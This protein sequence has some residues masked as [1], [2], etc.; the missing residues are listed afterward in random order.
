MFTTRGL[1][2]VSVALSLALL[3]CGSSPS[4]GSS[5]GSGSSSATAGKAAPE[6]TVSGWKNSSPLTLSGLNGKVVVLEF[7]A[8]WCGPC[9]STIAH[10]KQ[11][12]QDYKGKDLVLI[13][14]HAQKDCQK[15][16]D[17]VDSQGMTYPCAMDDTGDT[18]K[19]FGAQEL[20][21]IVL[22]DKK[23]NVSEL[24]VD[25]AKL[26]GDVDKLLAN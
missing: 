24:D 16:S 22:I 26:N 5:G 17:F 18:A 7:W 3:G 25:P 15:M 23:G 11:M 9:K 14:I 8:T 20:P 6:I 1:S 10:M 4:K 19:K 2:I 12:S 13:G 21:Y